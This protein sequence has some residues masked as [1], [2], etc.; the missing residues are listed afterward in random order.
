MEGSQELIALE[1]TTD[2]E[3]G[4]KVG[5]MQC[6]LKVTGEIEKNGTYILEVPDGYFVDG[7]GKDIKGVTLKYIVEKEG[8]GIDDVVVEGE[9]YW[10]VYDLTGVRVLE[11]ADAVQ[12]MT[13]PKGLYIVNGTKRIIK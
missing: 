6:A 5:Q 13:L 12:L 8:T 10:V 11:T 4:G 7:N 1:F 9:N 3:E 2:K